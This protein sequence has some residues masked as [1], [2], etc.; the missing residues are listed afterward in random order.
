M[1]NENFIYLGILLNS[2]GSI[3]YIIDTVKG[4]VKPNRVTF[5]LWALA[6]LIIF[7]SEV[8]QGVGIQA[9]LAFVVGFWPLLTLLA[10][11]TNKKAEW[12]ITKFDII[13]GILSLM[14]FIL[15]LV[16]KVGN[17][18]IIFSIM[19]DGLAALPTVKKSYQYP[20]TE[21]VW[22]YFTG[23]IYAGITILTIKTWNFPHYAFPVYLFATNTLLAVL[24]QFDFKKLLRTR[25]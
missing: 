6:P 1:I 21:N 9:L 17:I 14:G 24:I 13:C 15:W 18:A 20:E 19:A 4:K 16:T 5:F 22:I 2:I 10:S 25:S 12:R 23:A 3:S 7:F 11:F 8:K